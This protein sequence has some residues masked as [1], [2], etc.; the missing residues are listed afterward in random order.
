MTRETSNPRDSGHPSGGY[1]R[2]HID[3]APRDPEFGRDS[4]HQAALVADQFHAGKLH[5]AVL[6]TTEQANQQNLL[7][8]AYLRLRQPEPMS[9]GQKIRK[10]RDA[11]GLTQRQVATKLKVAPSAVAQWELDSTMPTIGNRVDLSRL[12]NIPFSDLMPEL[13]ALGGQDI[14]DPKIFAIVEQ[15]LRLPEPVREAVLM[16]AA[17]TVEALE[18][19]GKQLPPAEEDR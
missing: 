17:A 8:T 6:S 13:V 4:V 14:K 12:L 16:Q 7:R 5:S 9:I 10:G 18:R 15:L 3:G 19:L 1:L 2:P 11:A